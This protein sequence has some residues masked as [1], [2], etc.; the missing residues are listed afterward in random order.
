MDSDITTGEELAGAE[1]MPDAGQ[2]GATP[3]IAGQSPGA[4]APAPGGAAGGVPTL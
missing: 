1:I 3:G 2:P 4:G